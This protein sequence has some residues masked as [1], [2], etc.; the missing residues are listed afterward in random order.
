MLQ[1]EGGASGAGGGG[2]PGEEFRARS[3]NN[4]NNNNNQG[5]PGHSVRSRELAWT[6]G[7]RTPRPLAPPC[8]AH[9]FSGAGAGAGAQS[10]RAAR[11]AGAAAASVPGEG[12]T[13][14]G[15]AWWS[16]RRL[17]NPAAARHPAASPGIRVT[18]TPADLFPWGDWGGPVTSSHHPALTASV[19]QVLIRALVFAA[20]LLGFSEGDRF[21]PGLGDSC[22]PAPPTKTEKAHPVGKESMGLQIFEDPIQ[23]S[24]T[25]SFSLH[26]T[27]AVVVSN[28][29][30]NF[31]EHNQFIIWCFPTGY[32]PQ[33]YRRSEEKG[34]MHP[35]VHSSI[36][37]NS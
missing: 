22:G 16:R 34:H 30:V 24:M 13:G 35:D 31:Q 32:L 33:R 17:P 1:Q 11:G 28:S 6:S 9:S 19:N 21:R 4:N 36:V 12:L 15:G 26:F 2:G 7:S 18:K 14:G 23:Q 3:I 37:H 5:H 8:A 25:T 27:C 29:Q 10:A 20:P